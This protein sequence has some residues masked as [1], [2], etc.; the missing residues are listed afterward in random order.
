MNYSL[1]LYDSRSGS[2]FLSS[3][4]NQYSGIL[5]LPETRMPYHILLDKNQVYNS[6]EK[7]HNLLD[8]IYEEKQ[9]LELNIK[10]DEVLSTAL[11]NNNLTKE[12]ILELI[13]RLYF[14]E[15]ELEDKEI[16]LKI[17]APYYV[18]DQLHE[19]LKIMKVIHLVRDGRA[20][21][22]SK[23][24]SKSLTKKSFEKNLLIAAVGWKKK[25][26]IFNSYKGVKINIRYEDLI[27]DSEKEVNKILD[28]LNLSESRR[29]KIKKRSAY[30]KLIGK[31]QK[32]FHQNIT[33]NPK[34]INP[35]KF[36]N[37]LSKGQI[38][39]YEWVAKDVL[40]E[41]GYKIYSENYS[42]FNNTVTTVPLFFKYVLH[43][44]FSRSKLVF[45]AI[46]DGR[47]KHKFR[48]KL[49]AFKYKQNTH[50]N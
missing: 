30:F 42:F 10:R 29:I 19:F 1:I 13:L 48:D 35:N 37:N 22:Y 34:E 44:L 50:S 36:L 26:N 21:F 17:P 3:I 12:K 16:I 14:K 4:L 24:S 47:F 7:L 32:E 6:N 41:M 15:H 25:I 11:V 8:S 2:T 40:H 23:L 49:I 46:L 43:F 31:E 33:K 9:F 28:L 18:L 5:M 27:L 38:A 20:V 45:E 39:L